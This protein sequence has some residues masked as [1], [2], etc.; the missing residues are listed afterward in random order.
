MPALLAQARVTLAMATHAEAK[1]GGQPTDEELREVGGWDA[2]LPVGLHVCLHASLILAG[3]VFRP[4]KEGVVGRW[5][6]YILSFT[7]PYLVI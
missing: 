1:L 7:F 6:S 4:M 3:L 2:E 5:L